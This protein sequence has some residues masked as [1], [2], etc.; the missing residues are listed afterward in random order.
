MRNETQNKLSN[1]IDEYEN[2]EKVEILKNLWGVKNIIEKNKNKE[3][4]K[5]QYLDYL[6]KKI[7]NKKKEKQKKMKQRQIKKK[8]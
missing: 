3:I 7:E 4:K 1:L 5:K 8:A 6:D 2:E